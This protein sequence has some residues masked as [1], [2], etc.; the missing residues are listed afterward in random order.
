MKPRR[1]RRKLAVRQYSVNVAT[2]KVSVKGAADRRANKFLTSVLT[3]Q[4]A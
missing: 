3:G 4:F 2:G 1:K